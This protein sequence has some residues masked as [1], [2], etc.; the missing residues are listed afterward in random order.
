MWRLSS[1][2]DPRWNAS[3]ETGSGD[4]L[5]LSQL[6]RQALQALRA[7]LGEEPPDDLTTEVKVTAGAEPAAA[8]ETGIR[9]HPPEPAIFGFAPD[10][11]AA[12]APPPATRATEPG[13]CPKCGQRV[14][15]RQARCLQCNT[16][17][18]EEVVPVAAAETVPVPAPVA[19]AGGCP[20]C[21]RPLGEDAV[22]CINCGYDL[23]TGKRRQTRRTAKVVERDDLPR[24]LAQ[25]SLGLGFYYARAVVFLLTAVLFLGLPLYGMSTRLDPRQPDAVVLV[26][27]LAI[28]VLGAVWLV[29]GIAGAVL[30]AFVPR[31]AGARW[32]ILASLVLDLVAI[33]VGVLL[34]VWGG[35]ERLLW[36]QV[37]GMAILLVGWLLFMHYL[38][39]LAGYL[40][41]S[42]SVH[43]AGG[44]I[45]WGLAVV[46]AVPLLLV[47]LFLMAAVS[48][49]PAPI[50]L[51]VAAVLV[52]GDLVMLLK[53]V[54]SLLRLL[55]DLREAISRGL[56]GS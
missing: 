18:L 44:I 2:K 53:L 28:L 6:A 21:G 11:P 1:R 35:V 13:R 47:L 37:I 40:G 14:L 56:S 50:F 31:D 15:P 30:C 42:G 46:V 26:A 51:F 55:Q 38:R 54:F 5:T 49:I 45:V 23:R 19:A 41:L 36:A 39:Q 3:G 22:L 16:R 33:P 29:L 34:G 43:D 20:G 9:D 10:P 32:L 7:A 12:Q 24:S 52:F 4:P 25:V 17:L 8:P 48:M 27:S